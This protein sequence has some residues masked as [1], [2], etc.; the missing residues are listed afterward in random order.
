[1]FLIYDTGIDWKHIDFRKAGDTTKSRIL[2]MWDQ[3]LT[4]IAGESSPLGFNYGVEYTEAQIESELNGT[5]RN[6]IREQDT[7]GHGTHVARTNRK[8]P[9]IQ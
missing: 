6:Y 1:M 3:T 7:Y 2:F 8:W 4:P 9:G 5:K